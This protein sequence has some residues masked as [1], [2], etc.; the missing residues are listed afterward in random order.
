M[1]VES[2]VAFATP[3]SEVEAGVSAVSWGAI[4]AGAVAAAAVTLILLA[5]GAGVGFAVVSPWS[6]TPAATTFHVTT[7]LY[8]VVTAMIA[9]SIGGYLAG[10]LRRAW[11]GVH[12]REVFF[13]DTAHGFLAWG[14]ATLLSAAVLGSA[15]GA[16]IGGSAA[17][18]THLTGQA[19]ALLDP[20]ADALLV[21]DPAAV[22]NP[23]EAAAARAEV[24]RL[25]AASIAGDGTGGAPER[26]SLT[27]L[28]EGRTGVSRAQA[29]QRVAET[30]ARAKDAVDAA[31][32]AAAKLSLWLTASLL[33]GAFSASLAAI[34][35]G[36]L[37]DGTWKYKV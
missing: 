12:T 19:P 9:S 11:T 31:R 33:I 34:E 24:G 21:G 1:T 28:V 10:R 14:F 26:G 15:A 3:R 22:R 8:L 30:I 13:R 7:G 25:F 17:G 32:R 5:F 29:D 27:Q 2:S 37:R 20:Y 16:L 4:L 35:G 6:A 18:A 36:G 23:T